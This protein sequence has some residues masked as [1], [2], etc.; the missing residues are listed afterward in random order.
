VEK[1]SSVLINELMLF[2]GNPLNE[3]VHDKSWSFPNLFS[4]VKIMA[5]CQGAGLSHEM[6]LLVK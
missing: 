6:G 5:L 2:Y 3:G 1:Y 4:G